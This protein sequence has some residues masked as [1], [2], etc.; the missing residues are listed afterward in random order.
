M[1][2]N[3]EHEGTV[4]S[5]DKVK[6]VDSIGAGDWCDIGTVPPTISKLSILRLLC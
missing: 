5:T 4:V 6:A 2:S 1:L 3:A